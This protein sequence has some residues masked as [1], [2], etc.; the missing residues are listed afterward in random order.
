MGIERCVARQI[1]GVGL[2]DLRAA[3]GRRVPAVK[4]AVCAGR[5]GQGA[6]CAAVGY[7]DTCRRNTAAVGVEGDSVGLPGAL[8]NGEA[9][10]LR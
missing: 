9:W 4:G 3:A 8:C 2:V 7:G 10:I 5:S 6:V 1:Y